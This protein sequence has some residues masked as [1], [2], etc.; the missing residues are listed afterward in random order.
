[1]GEVA[2]IGGINFSVDHLE[3]HGAKAK[4]DYA[5]RIEGPVVDRI[6]RFARRTLAPVR[7]RLNIGRPALRENGQTIN[8]RRRARAATV[9]GQYRCGIR[10]PR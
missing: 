6:H 5:V 8:R 1:M 9:A 2:F 4:Q 10:Q 7:R 3:S